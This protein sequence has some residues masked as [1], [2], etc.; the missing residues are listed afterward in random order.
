MADIREEASKYNARDIYNMDEPGYNWK[1]IPDISLGTS[2][3]SGGKKSK[4]RIIAVFCCNSTGTDRIPIW[5]IGT[6]A[7][8]TCFRTARIQDLRALGAT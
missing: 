7:R 4:A 6:A 8:P 5:Y 2:Q 1:L 3:H